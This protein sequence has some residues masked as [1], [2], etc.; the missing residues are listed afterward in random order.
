MNKQLLTTAKY[1]ISVHDIESLNTFY[2]DIKNISNNSEYDINYQY[3][4][5]QLLNY[6]CLKKNKEIIIFL[7]RIYYE[8]FDEVAQIAL[9]QSFIYPKY[10]IKDRL[11]TEWYTNTILPL[12]K[13][14]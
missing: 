2:Y 5:L 7:T 6:A 12:I 13:C 1:Y 14:R 10:L 8:I 11:L 4:F 3:I 9:R